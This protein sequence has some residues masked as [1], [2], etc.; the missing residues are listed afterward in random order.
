MSSHT[1]VEGQGG[2]LEDLAYALQCV[3]SAQQRL[4]DNQDTVPGSLE[5]ANALD[6]ASSYLA[7][8]LYYV[9]KVVRHM[10][11]AGS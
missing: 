11:E 8:S 10:C 4:S 5:S 6:D 2:P 9:V 1:Y 3:Q 7:T